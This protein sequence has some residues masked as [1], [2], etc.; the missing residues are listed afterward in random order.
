M[1]LAVPV[2]DDLVAD[3]V[4]ADVLE[5]HHPGVEVVV[6]FILELDVQSEPGREGPPERLLVDHYA[7]E[8]DQVLQL[9]VLG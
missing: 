7:E 2:E 5:A 9:G 3:D 1:D 4:D 8:G 6:D